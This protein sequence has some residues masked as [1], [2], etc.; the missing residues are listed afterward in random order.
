MR[1]LRTR[2]TLGRRCAPACP[3]EALA[4]RHGTTGTGTGTRQIRRSRRPAVTPS[5]LSARARQCGRSSWS[6]TGSTAPKRRW[7]GPRRFGQVGAWAGGRPPTL[8]DVRS[9]SPIG[10]RAPLG[11]S[12]GSGA[13]DPRVTYGRNEASD[14]GIERSMT[15]A[16]WAA[17]AITFGWAG[18]AF[19]VVHVITRVP[20]S[21][22]PEPPSDDSTGTVRPGARLTELGRHIVAA[23]PWTLRCSTA[24]F[25]SVTSPVVSTFQLRAWIPTTVSSTIACATQCS[26]SVST[27]NS[28]G[29][30]STA[31]EHAFPV[32]GWIPGRCAVRRKDAAVERRP[33]TR[34]FVARGG[35][36]APAPT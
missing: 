13:A 36:P 2:R 16:D 17:F 8:H 10:L 5:I 18:T 21:A 30:P 9:S 35:P 22:R 1:T 27:A 11:R 6:S 29:S 31:R 33:V 34:R 20:P 23:F 12:Q 32:R 25:V 4:V 14:G 3:R 7:E 24:K 28:T 15:V 26:R 19:W